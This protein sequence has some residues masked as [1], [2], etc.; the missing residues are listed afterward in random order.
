MLLTGDL[1]YLAVEPFSERFPDRFFNVGVAEQNMVGIATGLARTGFLPF[2][3]SIATF[4]TL[5]PYE[6]IRNGPV[7]HQLPVRI[8][9]VGGGFEYGH[10]GITH[11]ALE[12]LAVTRVQPGLRIVVPA[13]ALQARTALT[14]TWALDGPCYYRLG[15]D[16]TR[17]VRGLDG[18]F[19]AGVYQRIRDGSDL[20]LITSGSI[21]SEVMDAAEAL[22][23][24]GASA[25]VLVVDQLNSIAETTLIDHIRPF[26]TILTIEAHC[27]RG[28]L[29]SFVSE[30]VAEA[31]MA[32]RVVRCGVDGP[33]PSGSG[34]ES[35]MNELYGLS[36]TQIVRKAIEALRH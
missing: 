23:E 1:G 6:F 28:G 8:V 5:R 16:E 3:Y 21:S 18:R 36:S 19:T 29:G 10:N 31:G 25:A 34:S 24:K 35:F 33:P 30:V 15:K 22:E 20:I 27:R 12:D 13:D 17:T 4:A 11:Y 2:V 14:E 7:I 32:S 9:G 26:D